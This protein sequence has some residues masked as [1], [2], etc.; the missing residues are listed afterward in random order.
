MNILVEIAG[1]LP[2]FVFPIATG[3]QL[4][5]ILRTKNVEGISLTTW[6]LFG[7]ANTSLYI[8]TEKYSAPQTLL[9]MLGTAFMDF[10]IVL[11]VLLWRENPMKHTSSTKN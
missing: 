8:Y 9:G 11:L 10:L 7:M 4:I 2:A 1:W 3:V 5:S 6:M